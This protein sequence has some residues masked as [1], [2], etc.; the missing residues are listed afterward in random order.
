[1]TSHDEQSHWDDYWHKRAAKMRA[2]KDAGLVIVQ[3]VETRLHIGAPYDP[4]FVVLAKG[5]GGQWKHKAQ[6]WSF[7]SGQWLAGLRAAVKCF[8]R[9]KLTPDWLHYLDTELAKGQS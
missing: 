9:G 3:V 2:A 7:P 8:G 4:L 6:V 1:M 5:A